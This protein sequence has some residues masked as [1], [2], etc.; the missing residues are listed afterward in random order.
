[1]IALGCRP[2]TAIVK[3]FISSQRSESIALWEFEKLKRDHQLRRRSLTAGG[4]SLIM[5]SKQI[6]VSRLRFNTFHAGAGLATFGIHLIRGRVCQFLSQI[7][8][9]PYH[10]DAG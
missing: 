1:V 5:R 6:K 9:Q 4:F 3:G 10:G 2:Q 8:A 7:R